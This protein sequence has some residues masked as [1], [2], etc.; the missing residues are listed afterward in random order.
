MPIISDMTSTSPT[1]QLLHLSF[2]FSVFFPP[3]HLILISSFSIPKM[4]DVWK[5]MTNLIT[6]ITTNRQGPLLQDFL[7]GGVF[8]KGSPLPDMINCDS[9]QNSSGG[10]VNCNN[11][12]L[13]VMCSL[14]GSQVCFDKVGVGVGVGVDV[15]VFER[16]KMDHDQDLSNTGSRAARRRRRLI[17]N[18]ESAARSR[19]RKQ[20]YLVW[21]S[22]YINVSCVCV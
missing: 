8:Y 20:V 1:Y 4:E 17:N 7:P 10:D 16:K 2:P 5:D 22:L 14:S 6:N 21:A 15:G 18:R 12:N 11:G 9:S 3:L 13:E 19:A